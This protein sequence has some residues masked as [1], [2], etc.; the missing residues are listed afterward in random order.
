[1][2]CYL[3]IKK[4][5]KWIELEKIIL[6]EATQIPQDKNCVFSYMC[7]LASKTAI[8]QLCATIQ[9]PQRLGTLVWDNGGGEDL[10]RKGNSMYCYRATKGKLEYED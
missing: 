7:M 6:S 8:T 4:E 1:M 3:A 9:I 10:L 5:I 2:E